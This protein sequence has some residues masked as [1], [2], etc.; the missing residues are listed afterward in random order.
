VLDILTAIKLYLKDANWLLGH[1]RVF[2]CLCWLVLGEVLL[3]WG[4][5]RWFELG[6]LSRVVKSLSTFAS[7]VSLSSGLSLWA[8][9]LI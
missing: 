4:K 9:L 5:S 3:L 1:L 6:R 8:S 2:H 7:I